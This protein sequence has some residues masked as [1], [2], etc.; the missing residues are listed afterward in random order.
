MLHGWRRG[1][2]RRNPRALGTASRVSK[3]P[4]NFNA[5]S[6]RPVKP[7]LALALVNPKVARQEGHKPPSR[8]SLGVRRR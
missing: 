3:A 7:I 8:L 4:V 5:I 6:R 2:K 1:L